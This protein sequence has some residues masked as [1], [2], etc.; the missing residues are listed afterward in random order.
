MKQLEETQTDRKKRAQIRLEPHCFE[1]H[2]I[3][4]KS[5]VHSD[6]R[7]NVDISLLKKASKLTHFEN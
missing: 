1:T 5:R 6:N 3:H 7:K 2:K 4:L